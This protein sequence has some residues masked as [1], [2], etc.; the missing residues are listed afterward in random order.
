MKRKTASQVLHDVT[1]ELNVIP[2][3]VHSRRSGKRTVRLDEVSHI[4]LPIYIPHRTTEADWEKARGL[5]CPECHNEVMRL[6]PYGF[7]G[8]NKCCEGCLRNRRELREYKARIA[9]YKAIRWR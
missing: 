9:K 6:V 3:R 1:P 4:E 5:K 2:G 8:Q 7:T